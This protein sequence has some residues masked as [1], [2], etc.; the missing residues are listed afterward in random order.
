MERLL[1]KFRNWQRDTSVGVHNSHSTRTQ[2]K[3]IIKINP[4]S[5][6]VQD[7]VT[8]SPMKYSAVA[9]LEG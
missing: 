4:G 6:G 8:L 5:S 9:P 7:Y 1:T 2:R 3:M